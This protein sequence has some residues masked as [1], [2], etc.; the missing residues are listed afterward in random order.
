[1]LMSAFLTMTE[2]K[3]FLFFNV[4]M[5]KYP[6][7][8]KINVKSSDE[9]KNVNKESLTTKISFKNKQTENES[10]TKLSV[11]KTSGSC[12]CGEGNKNSS[13]NHY[14]RD[15]WALTP[16]LEQATQNQNN[17]NNINEL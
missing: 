2:I 13:R 10:R 6:K 16:G 4:K 11:Y 12:F 17:N 15:T 9:R 5:Q 8:I 1:M 7:V 3:R 14:P